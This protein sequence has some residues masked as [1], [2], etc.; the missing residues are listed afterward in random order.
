M[1]THYPFPIVNSAVSHAAAGAQVIVEALTNDIDFKSEIRSA[2]RLLDSYLVQR[3]P[4][5][6]H[7]TK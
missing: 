4:V 1:V 2:A 5:T 3:G 7:H 6:V